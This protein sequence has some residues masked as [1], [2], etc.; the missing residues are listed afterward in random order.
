MASKR[1][2]QVWHF[3]E[4]TTPAAVAKSCCSI[5]LIASSLFRAALHE[6]RE[7][8]V[9]EGFIDLSE[10][11]GQIPSPR[12]AGVAG[13][14]D[15]ALEQLAACQRPVLQQPLAVEDR[16]VQVDEDGVVVLRD[17]EGGDAVAHQVAVEGDVF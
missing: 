14:D 15:D 13:E 16:H 7:M 12:V 3:A 10:G 6:L 11:L 8:F 1:S 5:A 9:V 2:P 4:K 17:L